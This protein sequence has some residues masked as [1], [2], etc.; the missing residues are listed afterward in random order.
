MHPERVFAHKTAEKPDDFWA[1]GFQT[2][3]IL[4]EHNRHHRFITVTIHNRFLYIA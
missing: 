2:P 4:A 1:T 3:F